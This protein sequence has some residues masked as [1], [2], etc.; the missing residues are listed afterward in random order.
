MN[1][2]SDLIYRLGGGYTVANVCGVK[3]AEVTRWIS[4][5]QIPVEHWPAIIAS[6]A[7]K[8]AGVFAFSIE[9]AEI[10]AKNQLGSNVVP[11]RRFAAPHVEEDMA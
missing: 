4:D 1:A 2:V 10:E 7:A 9:A 3:F 6:P 8:A 11:F 5:R